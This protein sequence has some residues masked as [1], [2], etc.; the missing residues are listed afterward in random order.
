MS[1]INVNTVDT[2]CGSTLTL[3]SSGKTV[4]LASGASQ[5]GFGRTGTVD[6]QSGDIKTANFTA[7]NGEGYFCDTNSGSFT[8][9]LPS[10]SAGAIVSVQ[11][12]R[13]TFGTNALT[14]APAS[15]EKINTGVGAVS[16]STN[17]EGITLV[18]ID[19]TVGWRSVQDNQFADAGSNY[20]AAT[21][22]TVTTSGD[23][24]IHTFTSDGC[25]AVTSGGNPAGSTTVDYLVV[26]GG[27][28]G[29]TDLGGG[30]GAGG[31]RS[32]FPQPATGGFPVSVQTYPITVGGGGATAQC[33]PAP[34]G[35]VKGSNGSNSVF[36]T[37][38]SAGGGAAGG[39]ATPG[40]AQLAGSDG[41]SG[42]GGS[43]YGTPSTPVG[44]GN[45]PPVS[46]PQGNNGGTAN[47]G[48]DAYPGAGGGGS[49]AVGGTPPSVGASGSAGGAGTPNTIDGNSYSWAGGGGGGAYSPGAAAGNGGI[50]GGGGG[51]KCFSPSPAHPNTVGTGGA[52]L[53]N[54]A[55]G[56]AGPQSSGGPPSGGGAG[57]AN[58]GGGGGGGGHGGSTGVQ[59]FNLGGAGGSGIVVIRYKF[60]N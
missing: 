16:L 2:Q 9:T 44:Q 59:P 60:Q 13:N 23:F 47:G 41:G 15:G 10:G 14:V 53:N 57:G 50:G 48:A 43:G 18:Y 26:A 54:G 28:A 7:T 11:D 33:S 39:S 56:N 12:Y 5:S 32:Q 20:V 49:S 27:G 22:G 34:G 51:G 19:S 25:F 24:K 42:G 31:Y 37:I 45:T 3:G 46:P 4:T 38:T 35:P 52:G 58:T 1:K 21:G 40:P 55:D 36:S 29:G 8:V 17:G 30:G 6:W